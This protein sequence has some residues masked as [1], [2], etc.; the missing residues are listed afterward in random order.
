MTEMP[1]KAV[2][3]YGA[4][5]SPSHP[6]SKDVIYAAL[7]KVPIFTDLRQEDLEWFVERTDEFRFEAGEILMQEGPPA[8]LMF[9][10]LEGE[11]R[12][13]KEHSSPADSPVIT[14]EA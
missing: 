5:K 6:S 13:R 11:I 8:K 4:L 1:D 12:G 3:E 7:R 14:I 2:P 9:V 10:L